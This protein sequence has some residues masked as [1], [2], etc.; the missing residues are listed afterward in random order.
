MEWGNI[1]P[2]SLA[3]AESSAESPAPGNQGQRLR[4]GARRQGQTLLGL[5]AALILVLTAWTAFEVWQNQRL[6][7]RIKALAAVEDA[8]MDLTRTLLREQADLVATLE[9]VRRTW[10]ATAVNSAKSSRP[11]DALETALRGRLPR[12]YEL[13][14]ISSSNV[15]IAGIAPA[16][17]EDDLL[18]LQDVISVNDRDSVNRRLLVRVRS[19]AS[20]GIVPSLADIIVAVSSKSGQL[21]LPE[22][23]AIPDAEPIASCKLIVAGSEV[24]RVKAFAVS[25][26]T[27]SGL[28]GIALGTLLFVTLTLALA[29]M[30]AVR[31]ARLN[32]LAEREHQHM[33]DQ[34]QRLEA[35]VDAS[36][37][38][39]LLASASGGVELVNPAAEVMFG[40]IGEDMLGQKLSQLIPELADRTTRAHP[41]GSSG[42]RNDGDPPRIQDI[43]IPRG[44]GHRF[45]ARVWIRRVSLDDGPRQ[46]L[47]IQDL[48]ESAQQAEQMEFLEQRDVITGLLNRMEFERRMEHMLTEATGTE[49]PYAL[50][51]IDIDQFKL[52]NDTAGHAAGDALIE[53]LATLLEVKF[54]DASLLARLGGDEFG[55]LFANCSEEHALTLCEDLVHT[56]RN[57]LFT[58]R[59]R[60]FDIAVSIGVTAFLPEND[61]AVAELAKADVACHMAKRSGRDRVHVYHDGD[62][63]AARHHGEMRIASTISQ[64][65]NSG[66]FR[67]Y[68]QPIIPLAPG[69]VDRTH[70]EILV[71][72]LDEQ[73]A[74][75]VPDEFIPAAERYILMPAVDRWIIHQLFST[76]GDQLRS[77]HDEHPDQFLFAVN[78]SGTSLGDD[79]FLP[80]LKR[81][82]EACRIPPAG[83]CFE[84]T[85]T[86]A[87]RSLRGAR[88]FMHELS[89]MGCTFALD[90]FGSGLASYKYLRELP[91]QYLKIDGSFVHDMNSNPVN[92]ALVAS[93]N[94]IAHVL[95]LKTIAEWAEDDATINQ[96]RALNVDFVQGYAIGTPLPVLDYHFDVVGAFATE[97]HNGE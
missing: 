94:Q 49:T 42:E 81:Q 12:L 27:A 21:P 75:V 78:L 41:N 43:Q 9:E 32:L 62:A 4:A 44:D 90:D 65:L 56:V 25:S 97:E 46:L 68:A 88:G 85:E 52:V 22:G 58:W 71:R 96:L 38:G 73:G 31:I 13:R 24:A 10:A 30:L 19:D 84:I 40:Q 8:T 17:L 86:A 95:G 60:S 79:G 55:A 36:S 80:F 77:W 69:S 61:S 89:E 50:C 45:P 6:Q 18:L 70:Y 26:A 66:R 1:T 39:I 63:S 54:N 72:M 59:D 23:A 5:M 93:I 29:R 76:Q 91:V 7:T 53:Q 67:L 51:Y 83:I 2:N 82:F 47:M 37:D 48:T 92:H 33:K 57:F 74:P 34:R 20:A 11:A 14:A 87:I 28:V 64:A 3:E 16:V 15:Q 35:V